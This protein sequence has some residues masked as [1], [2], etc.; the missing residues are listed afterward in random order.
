[1]SSENYN[2]YKEIHSEYLSRF[3]DLHNYHQEF[4]DFPSY[5]KGA[6]VRKAISDMIILERKLRKLSSAVTSEHKK[7][8]KAGHLAEKREKARLR[9]IPKKRG[10]PKVKGIEA[11]KRGPGRPRKDKHGNNTTN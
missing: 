3:V 10:R 1:M 8:V 9:A 5:L 4:L 7:N 2:R 6:R 11:K